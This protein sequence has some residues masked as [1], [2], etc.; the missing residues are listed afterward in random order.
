MRD[1]LQPG[2]NVEY[3]H[4]NPYIMIIIQIYIEEENEN[5]TN[6]RFF[7][8]VFLDGSYFEHSFVESLKFEDEDK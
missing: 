4:T 2:M 6:I 3:Q 1:I 8:N 5:P 7:N